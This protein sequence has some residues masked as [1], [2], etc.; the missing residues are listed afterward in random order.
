MVDQNYIDSLITTLTTKRN[1]IAY[2]MAVKG[3]NGI[4]ADYEID[5]IKTDCI[6]E[7][8]LNY[9]IADEESPY[10]YIKQLEQSS[11]V[12]CKYHETL[13][14][15]L[16]ESCETPS[17]S[18]G[19]GGSGTATNY[20]FARHYY[21]TTS[22]NVTTNSGVTGIVL[23]ERPT[24]NIDVYINGFYMRVGDGVKTRDVY[25]SNDGGTTAKALDELQINDQLIINAVIIG[26]T[27]LSTDQV[28]LV[29]I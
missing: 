8:L 28:L 7:E 5:L 20:E 9:I 14:N 13:Y 19:G 18:G 16:L 6:I 25:F 24:L 29:I 10:D 3:L 15:D 2:S 12:N 11:Q 22:G 23:P 21:R 17:A 26:T 27:V 4:D 1:A